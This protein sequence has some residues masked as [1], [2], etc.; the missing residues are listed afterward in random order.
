M[1]AIYEDVIAAKEFILGDISGA[2]LTAKRPM[3]VKNYGLVGVSGG[4]L[5]F[6]TGA[7]WETVTST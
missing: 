4:K 5:V 7:K 3:S 1:A 6:Y 2:T